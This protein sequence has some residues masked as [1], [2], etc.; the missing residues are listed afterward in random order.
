MVGLT[1]DGQL[2][3]DGAGV[4]VNAGFAE[5]FER[6]WQDVAA[7][8]PGRRFSNV[9]GGGVEQSQSPR[10]LAHHVANYAAA[11]VLLAERPGPC[12][13]LELGCGSGLL[14]RAF[15]RTMPPDWE[16]V[17]T[18]RS[19]EWREL[20]AVPRL[21]FARLDVTAPTVVGAGRFDAVM[22]LELFEH[23][24]PAEAV[25]LLRWVHGI[26]PAGGRLVFSTLDR[27]AFP[28]PHS[29]YWPHR[30][31][32]TYGSLR[33]LLADRA[34]NPFGHQ[35]VLRLVSEPIARGAVRS[36]AAGGYLINRLVAVL[37]RGRARRQL[38][39]MG[40][41]TFWAVAGLLPRAKLP[42]AGYWRIRM[43]EENEHV[44]AAE[45]FGIVAELVKD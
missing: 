39:E 20:A 37:S 24:D 3:A 11:L 6:L 32:Y 12:R 8:R 16:L 21:E 19:D 45:C 14:S 35:R 9:E 23:L 26:L 22:M 5:V 34:F 42:P 40:L 33:R 13:L 41:R 15:A 25:R 43:T 38:L 27:S 29:G 31:E 10:L 36:E 44:N 30:V 1:A 17:A 4:V 28:R 7:A 2:P 18:D